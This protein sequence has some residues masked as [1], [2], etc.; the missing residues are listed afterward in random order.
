MFLVRETLGNHLPME[1]GFTESDI[2][3]SFDAVVSHIGVF[4]NIENEEYFTASQVPTIVFIH[5]D[6][7]ELA[8]FFILSQGYPADTAHESDTE[9]LLGPGLE[10]AKRAGNFCGEFGRRTLGRFARV[11]ILKVEFM[12]THTIP[13][14]SKTP[15]EFG[16]LWRARGF[17]G[18]KL[19]ERIDIFH[20]ALIEG[21]VIGEKGVG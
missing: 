18:E 20:V 4:E 19:T 13:F 21:E 9:K 12:Q 15:L 6:I 10:S 2:V 7:E 5:P 8:C 1:M 3:R 16:M 14:P 11:E 17:F